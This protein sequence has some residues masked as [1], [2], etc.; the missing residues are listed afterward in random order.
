MPRRRICKSGR[1][2]PP[3]WSTGLS[4]VVPAPTLNSP[5]LRFC[6]GRSSRVIMSQDFFLEDDLC[7]DSERTIMQTT[8][9][10]CTNNRSECT[11]NLRELCRCSVYCVSVHMTTTEM[12]RGE[13]IGRGCQCVQTAGDIRGQCPG[14]VQ[15]T[16][17]K[18]TMLI[19]CRGFICLHV[20]H[21]E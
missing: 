19:S 8:F 13:R 17:K 12:M 3:T 1:P 7:A 5:F 18:E 6:N 10:K 2:G 11:I 4:T 20:P 15:T 9:R 21:T 16:V 14:N